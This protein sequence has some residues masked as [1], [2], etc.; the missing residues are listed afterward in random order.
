MALILA[1]VLVSLIT[2]FL[3]S[4]C[5]AAL[6][7]VTPT[8]V[9]AI[10]LG[11]T[12][13]GRRLAQLR[14]RIEEA[15]AGL[16]TI[17]TIAQTAG[18]AWAGALVGEYYGNQWLG[19][20]SA[21]LT[22]AILLLAEIVPKSVGVAWASVLAVRLA[23]PIQV[24]IWLVWPLAWLCTLIMK[25]ITRRAPGQGPSEEEIIVMADLAAQGGAILPDESRWVKNV[26][27]LNNVTVRQ[28]MTPRN[29]VQALPADLP[30]D[31]VEMHA[32]QW[33]HSR[34]PVT[35]DSDLDRVVGL[36]Q[37]RA[38]FDQL[39]HGKRTKRLRDLM[40]PALF[41]PENLRGHQ[42]LELLIAQ[43]QHL[44]IVTDAAGQTSGVVSLEDVLEYLLGRPIVGEHDAH[45]EMERMTRERTQFHASLPKTKSENED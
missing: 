8:R 33:V 6:Y 16:G 36:V 5:E 12:S 44:A 38:V 23:W 1:V 43:R 42:L 19:A 34:V 11:G 32:Q 28:L 10:R 29:V 27:R 37:R 20:F 15:I 39:T 31:Q 7:A 18:A 41:V 22:L 30:L 26:L 13:S 21:F 40:R 4:L 17:N 9:E 3:C 2:S 25:R 35:E 24:M 14:E 45:P